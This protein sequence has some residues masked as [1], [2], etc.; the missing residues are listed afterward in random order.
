MTRLNLIVESTADHE[1]ENTPT[2][3]YPFPEEIAWVVVGADGVGAARLIVVPP[4][5]PKS[6]KSAFDK[7]ALL[8]CFEIE[9]PLN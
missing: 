2:E 1:K 8:G 9:P 6:V 7:A 3:K 4:V 5:G